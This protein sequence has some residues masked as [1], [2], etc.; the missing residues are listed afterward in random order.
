[1][2]NDVTLT[3]LIARATDYADMTGSSFP[4]TA[5]LIDAANA[6]MGELHD[7]LVASYG[8]YYRSESTI[9]L[10][11]GTESY[12]MPTD[13]YKINQVWLELGGKRYAVKKFDPRDLSNASM[14]PACTGSLKIWYTPHCPLFTVV[15]DKVSDK[16]KWLPNNW[17]EFVVCKMA[18]TLLAREQ[19]D[20]SFFE[21]RAELL[22]KN[23]IKMA[24]ER[25]NNEVDC[26][27][28]ESGRY[29]YVS[30]NIPNFLYRVLGE[31]I[32]IT[33]GPFRDNR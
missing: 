12:L 5:R 8:D 7:I 6:A 19:S 28:D 23:M 15:A 24:G 3:T 32:Y 16:L 30:Y 13:Y 27:S 21:N 2:S 25:D 20:P 11:A 10:V 18:A 9:A 22:R 31:K 29:N 26:I 1:M 33:Q 14:T 4:V 17:E